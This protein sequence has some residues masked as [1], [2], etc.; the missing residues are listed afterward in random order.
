MATLKKHLVLNKLADADD[1]RK[2]LARRHLLDFIT[3]DDPDYLIGKHHRLI[4]EQLE[5]TLQDVI[6]VK[7]HGKSPHDCENLRVIISMPP[8]H[9]KSRMASVEFP[10]WVLGKYPDLNIIMAS[11]ASDLSCELSGKCKSSLFRKREC[12]PNIRMAKDG[13]NSH[14]WCIERH[15]WGGMLATGVGGPITGHGADIAIIDDPIKNY[16]E[17]KSSTYRKRVADWYKS[18][19]RTRLSNAGAIIIIMTRWHEGDL[20]GVVESEEKKTQ[21]CEDAE[22]WKKL[23]VPAIAEENDLLG[24]EPGEALWPERYDIRFLRQAKASMGSYLFGALYQQHP[25]PEGGGVFKRSMFHYWEIDHGTY[26]LHDPSGDR[27]FAI[28]ACWHFTSVDPV[29]TAK[30]SSDYFVA[31][32][33]VVTP[34]ADLLLYDVYRGHIEASKQV[35]SIIDVYNRYHPTV[36]GIETNGI[37]HAPYQMIRDAGVPVME[38]RAK[39]DKVTKSLAMGARYEAGK[40]FHLMDASW[41]DDYEQELMMFP[42]G[43][44]DDQV[45]TASYA[46]I[47]LAELTIGK[48]E[49]SII[50][51]DMPYQIS[52]I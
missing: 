50:E 45:D 46:A 21:D 13:G 42:N 19:L 10:A 51:V 47:M 1:M 31:S 9:G 23:V 39:T 16:D 28:E 26:L 40:V 33:W 32:T 48:T 17:A 52:A 20:V 8:R 7:Y 11:Y 41:L 29:A 49:Q 3:Y 18:T 24:R 27:R 25:S 43:K 38:L 36:V 4:A 22:H 5:K 34:D 44:H 15:T 2:E 37:G 14:R 35:K 12:F 6:D 30:Q